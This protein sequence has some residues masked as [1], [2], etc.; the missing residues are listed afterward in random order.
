MV[1]ILSICALVLVAGCIGSE[2]PISIGESKL[3][4]YAKR[5][6]QDSILIYADVEKLADVGLSSSDINEKSEII[7]GLYIGD[8]DYQQNTFKRKLGIR[9][10]N[11]IIIV[12]PYNNLGSGY[13]IY[14]GKF[15]LNKIKEKLKEEGFFETDRYNGFSIYKGYLSGFLAIS[16]DEKYIIL[17][18]AKFYSP[19]YIIDYLSGKNVENSLYTQYKKIIKKLPPNAAWYA[20]ME[21]DEMGIEKAGMA[22][23]V[24]DEKVKYIIVYEFKN[25]E[26]AKEFI[27][28]KLENY[29]EDYEEIYEKF[30]F[31]REGKYVIVELVEEL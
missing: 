6:P 13:I 30:D 26:K 1:V 15:K 21:L 7:P 23:L 29:K 2:S 3:E 31:K 11:E 28:D 8:T 27:E 10:I 22:I 24:D 25:D 4:Y 20:L 18:L 19:R 16:N 9:K 14:T 17:H 5:C 12:S